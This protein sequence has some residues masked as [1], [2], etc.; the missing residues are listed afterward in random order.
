MSRVDQNAYYLP[1]APAATLAEG[2][3]SAGMSWCPHV[4]LA[5]NVP[6][7][8]FPGAVLSATEHLST[9][10]FPLSARVVGVSCWYAKENR[11]AWTVFF[12]EESDNGPTNSE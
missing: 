7:S 4:T 12:D 1:D 8:S 9:M 3:A 11:K 10:P 5:N 6:L 2:C